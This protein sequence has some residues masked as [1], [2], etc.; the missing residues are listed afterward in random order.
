MK[1]ALSSFD[2]RALV[3]EWQGLVGGYID[4]VYQRDDEV[5]FRI[6]VPDHGKVELY[7]KSGRWLCLHEVENKP[8]S[9]PA[10]AQ[11]LRR[12]LDN[13]RVTAVEQRGFDRIAVF[14]IE[15]GP[16]RFDVVFE[17]FGKGN[18]VLVRDGTTV[19]ALYPQK[20]KDRT[21]Q[22]G[23]PY[24][25][26][27][28]GVDP[29]E[30]DRHGFADAL[31]KAKGQVVRVLASVMNLGGTYAEELCLRAGLDKE[32][33]VK[34]L[35]PA[36]IDSLYTAL[37]NLAVAVEQERRPAV[38]FQDGHAIDATPIELIQY[39]ELERRE[40][41]SFNEAL[42]HFL[43]VAEPE[44]KVPQELAAKFERRIAQQQETQRS[45]R[46]EAMLL[47]A[48]AV[49]LY[50][51][52]AVLDE[53]LKAVREGRPSPEHGQ[54]K[55]IDRKAHTITLA[56]GDFDAIVLDYEKDVT[57]NAQA[58]YDRRKEA[59]LKAQ[60]V[61]EA[62]AQTRSEM[63]ATKAKAVQAA[64]KPRVKATKSLWFEAY[65]WTLSSEGF[66]ILGGRDAR[67]NDQLVKKHLKEG[68]RYAHADIHG[69]PSTVVKEGAKASEVTLRE[70]CEFALAYSKAWSSGLASGSAYWVLPEQV[71]KQAES[72]EFLPRGAFVIRGKR[73]YVHDLPVWVAIGEVEIEGHRKIMG[74]PV[75]AVAARATRYLVLA[76]GKEDRDAVAKRLAAAFVVP[77]EEIVRTMPP[78]GV[79]VVERHGIEA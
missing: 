18:L 71:S 74:G 35:S 52:Y 3:A 13:A 48:Q 58:L 44:A 70:A 46:E 73:N 43:T 50:N 55:A 26:P 20:F 67:T 61:D 79:Q 41:P 57:A 64:K 56:I 15:R 42:S 17:V 32:A 9:P 38:I 25:Y 19:A 75:S 2:L 21:V 78:G 60:R 62:I 11:A 14:R 36:Q 29:L 6:N 27:A 51:H 54:I 34:E 31:T 77:I 23:E 47:E 65:R 49:F 4:K 10:F 66:L 68:D 12:L 37:N 72:G 1:Q 30:V 5:I 16:E 59:L 40:F 76:P 8:E 7:S 33:R 63:E 39:R 53:L 28:A 22:V 45:L 24:K 69:A